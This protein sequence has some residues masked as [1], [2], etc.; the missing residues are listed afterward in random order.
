MLLSLTKTGEGGSLGFVFT[1]VCKSSMGWVFF[2]NVFFGVRE[3]WVKGRL[4]IINL[5]WYYFLSFV[6][7]TYL[8]D[9]N[10]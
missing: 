4:E 9:I 7:F 1:P 8:F 5:Q 6:Q 10:A 3:G 2:V